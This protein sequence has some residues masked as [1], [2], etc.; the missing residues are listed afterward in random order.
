MAMSA[1]L[2][3]VVVVDLGSR[4]LEA[5][6]HL[7]EQG[8]EDTPFLLQRRDPGE[9]EVKGTG[10]DNHTYW[11]LFD[12]GCPATARWQRQIV[13]A[14]GPGKGRVRVRRR[15]WSRPLDA[16]RMGLVG[17]RVAAGGLLDLGLVA[18][19]SLCRRCRRLP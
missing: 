14:F 16:Q 7:V 12:W 17:L 6:P 2:P 10:S 15:T 1:D 9:I 3:D 18:I 5:A 13:G 8:L 19:G 11:A 4:N